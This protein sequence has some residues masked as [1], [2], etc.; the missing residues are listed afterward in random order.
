M[1]ILNAFPLIFILLVVLLISGS[2]TE[3]TH[4]PKVERFNPPD[5]SDGIRVGIPDE[6]GL[7]IL[8]LQKVLEG[9]KTDAY[10]DLN[11]ILVSRKDCLNLWGLRSI[12]E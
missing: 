4:Q 11:S 10:R 3:G 1:R 12:Q 7:N 8:R 9:V 2:C 5:L 6:V